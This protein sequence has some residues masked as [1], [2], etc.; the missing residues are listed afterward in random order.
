MNP[1]RR[2]PLSQAQISGEAGRLTFRIW[3]P[4]AR[5]ATCSERASPSLHRVRHFRPGQ[6][7]R[8]VAEGRTGEIMVR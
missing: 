5:S 6:M 4:P 1:E 2:S 7:R 3:T 8:S